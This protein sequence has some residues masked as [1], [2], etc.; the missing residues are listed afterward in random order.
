MDPSLK[1][2]SL[3]EAGLAEAINKAEHYRLLNEPEQAESICLDVL[4]LRPNESRALVTLILALTDQFGRDATRAVTA[5]KEQLEHLPD[6]Y[7]RAYYAG[8]IA[9]RQHAR[10]SPVGWGECLRTKRS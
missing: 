7:S 9:E 2:K 6:A 10:S 8:L 5:A 1:I 4:T 3:T